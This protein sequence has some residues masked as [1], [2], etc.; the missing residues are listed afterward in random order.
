MRNEPLEQGRRWLRQAQEDLRW[1]RLLAEQ[2]GYH[3]ACFLAQQIT[4]V[5]G[6]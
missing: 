5:A 6:T 1:A 3:L 2:G 4:E